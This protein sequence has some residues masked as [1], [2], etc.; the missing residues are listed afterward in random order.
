MQDELGDFSADIRVKAGVN[1]TRSRTGGFDPNWS[2]G[3]NAT[4]APPGPC[5]P[6]NASH[7]VLTVCLLLA[8]VAVHQPPYM[9]DDMHA[10]LWSEEIKKQFKSGI[11]VNADTEASHL[12]VA[13]HPISPCRWRDDTTV[14]CLSWRRVAD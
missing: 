14:S 8:A 5:N 12:S 7:Q 1:P 11:V 13:L 9:D 2:R 3:W 10:H 6:H 4:R